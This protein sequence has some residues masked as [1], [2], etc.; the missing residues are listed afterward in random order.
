MARRLDYW[1]KEDTFA[2]LDEREDEVF[3]QYFELGAVDRLIDKLAPQMQG[4]AKHTFYA[5]L[6]AV[7]GRWEKFEEIREVRAYQTAEEAAAIA[8]NAEQKT[9]NADRLRFEAKRWQAEV[10]NRRAF[11]KRPEVQLAV[12]VGGEW[13]QA[14]ASV[15][16]PDNPR[17]ARLEGRDPSE[18]KPTRAIGPGIE[19]GGPGG[20]GVQPDGEP[21]H[22]E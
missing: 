13:A 6:H 8:L 19:L 4:L 15:F 1:A 12:G 7:D 22:D 20:E 21:S 2:W 9:A 11:G 17:S 14:L 18:N 5:W 10:Q 3:A 16:E